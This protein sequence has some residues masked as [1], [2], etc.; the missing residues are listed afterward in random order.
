MRHTL[1]MSS[2]YAFWSWSV[3]T[4]F[5]A[6]LAKNKAHHIWSPIMQEHFHKQ[7]NIPVGSILPTFVV[8]VGGRVWCHSLSGPMFL[9]KGA[10][11][12]SRVWHYPPWT[13]RC[14]K[15]YLPPTP[16]VGGN[17]CKESEPLKYYWIRCN[18]IQARQMVTV[19]LAHNSSKSQ[20]WMY[21]HTGA[22]SRVFYDN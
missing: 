2:L 19:R 3:Y 21:L 12:P 5:P 16:F 15:H 13:D 14:K 20:W 8:P 18:R 9:P 11:G 10:S 22:C 6:V 4:N 17:K 1:K 7:E